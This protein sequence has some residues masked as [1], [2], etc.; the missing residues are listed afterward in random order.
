[1]ESAQQQKAVQELQNSGKEA[2]Q[3]PASELYKKDADLFAT[4]VEQVYR[5]IT[6]RKLHVLKGLDGEHWKL[7][8]K[9]HFMLKCPR[10]E[11]NC[12]EIFFFKSKHDDDGLICVKHLLTDLQ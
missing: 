7:K 12:E 6:N 10:C 8:P 3:Q 9:I 11:C 2:R 5:E 4:H 1:M